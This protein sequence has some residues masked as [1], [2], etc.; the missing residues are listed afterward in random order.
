MTPKELQKKYDEAEILGQ[1]I[2]ALLNKKDIGVVL[3][4]LGAVLADVIVKAKILDTDL[5]FE[6]LKECLEVKRN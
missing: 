1:E 6:K 2:A 5:Y 4:A 3:M